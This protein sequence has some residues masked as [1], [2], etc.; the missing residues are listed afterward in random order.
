MDRK[1]IVI[2]TN[3]LISSLGWE[4]KSREL[5]RKVI[6][7]EFELFISN[8]QLEEIKR[9]LDYPK[10]KFTKQQKAQFLKILFQTANIIE[11]KTELDVC[12]DNQDNMIIECAVEANAACIIS[13]DKGLRKIKK[14][15][16]IQIAS[17]NEFL[18][19]K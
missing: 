8:K 11:T 16:D 10:F 13:G 3:N 17:V 7:S 4:G 14:Y 9:V 15:K 5:M 19:E 2:D 12:D 6:N 18:N 1:K